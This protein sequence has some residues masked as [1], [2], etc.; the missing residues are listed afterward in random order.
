MRYL[1]YFWYYF[2][3]RCTSSRVAVTCS[4]SFDHVDA[5]PFQDIASSRNG[6]HRHAD[7]ET[8]KQGRWQPEVV[9]SVLWDTSPTARRHQQSAD[10]DAPSSNNIGGT[11]RQF[12][13]S[14]T[15]NFRSWNQTLLSSNANAG[16]E[17]LTR[18]RSSDYARIRVAREWA[19]SQYHWL[20]DVSV[21]WSVR[22]G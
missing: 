2:S 14:L 11:K 4:K 17:R 10:Q 19:H 20:Y 7:G 9:E 18:S 1:Q 16:R 22:I 12:I 5:T 8:G 3:F 21:T 13:T 15:S 6:R